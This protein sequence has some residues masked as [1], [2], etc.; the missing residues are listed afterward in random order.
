MIIL[1]VELLLVI[2]SNKPGEFVGRDIVVGMRRYGNRIQTG[3]RF[4]APVQAGPGAHSLLYI[5]YRVFPRDEAAR[6]WR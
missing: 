6:V 5:G 1:C 4:S 3:A 2:N